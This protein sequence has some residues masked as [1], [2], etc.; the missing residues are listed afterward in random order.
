MQHEIAEHR[1]PEP[2]LAA[3]ERLPTTRGSRRLGVVRRGRQSAA[4]W[5]A[6]APPLPA[7]G[8]LTLSFNEACLT[9]FKASIGPGCLSVRSPQHSGPSLQMTPIRGAAFQRRPVCC[10]TQRDASSLV[11]PP[12]SGDSND[13]ALT[14]DHPGLITGVLRGESGRA[15]HRCPGGPPADGRHFV[16]FSAAPTFRFDWLFD[17][18]T[19]W[20]GRQQIES[21]RPRLR[22][23]C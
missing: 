7:G 5:H 17:R 12:F 8:G 19:G 16:A 11:V 9:L 3:A 22:S 20:G 6:M 21:T 14:P 13:G 18:R 15:G 10:L 4:R 23:A 2:W 1:A